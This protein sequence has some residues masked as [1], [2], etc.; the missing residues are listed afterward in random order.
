MIRSLSRFYS[1]CDNKQNCLMNLII[2]LFLLFIIYYLF[3]LFIAIFLF[4]VINFT[5][6]ILSIL[7]KIDFAVTHIKIKNQTTRSMRFFFRLFLK[8][9]TN[10]YDPRQSSQNKHQMY[11][12]RT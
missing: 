7:I 10:L 4:I 8:G 5:L 2:Y 12:V 9:E 1:L 11:E 3:I 6:N